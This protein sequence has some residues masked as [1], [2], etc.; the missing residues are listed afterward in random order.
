MSQISKTR[1]QINRKLAA[2]PTYHDSIPLQQIFNILAE[3]DVQVLD[4]DGT[5]WSGILC[6]ENASATFQTNVKA[7][8]YLSWYRMP[9]GKYE[10]VSYVS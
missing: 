10:I 9:S 4:V 2:L 6:G 8:L 3:S 1:T 5:P 7:S